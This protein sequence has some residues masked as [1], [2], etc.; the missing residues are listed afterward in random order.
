M[1][2]ALRL[3]RDG[4]VATLVID[5][6]ARRNAMTRAMWLALPAL[7]A[8]A[9]ADDGVALL[10]VQ[11]TGG[12]FCAGADIAEFAATYATAEGA[13]A[14]NVAI[15]AAADALAACPKPSVAVIRG[16]CVGGGVALALA[17]DLRLAAP[18]ARF[19]VTPAKLGLIYSHADTLRLVRAVGAA[20]AKD[21]LFTAR[22]VEAEEALRIGLV[23]RIAAA[24]EVEACCAALATASRPALRATK[25]MVAAIEAGAL[26]ETPDLS[27]LFRDAFSGADFREGRDAF[28]AKRAPVFTAR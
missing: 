12:H 10:R 15:A 17:C 7:V 26:R 2:G 11:G 13:E 22:V 14:A 1:T 8:Q 28:L 16:A 27:A 6:P 3:E 4:A 24:A 23:Q 20:M 25:A 9:V 19:A 5:Q 18:D 21:L